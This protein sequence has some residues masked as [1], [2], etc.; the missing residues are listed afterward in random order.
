M[1]TKKI[2]IA[3][4]L[5]PVALDQLDAMAQERGRSRSDIIESLVSTESHGST[6]WDTTD[7]FDKAVAGPDVPNEW[8]QAAVAV[9]DTLRLARLACGSVF[10]LEARDDRKTAI[11]VCRMMLDT[12]ERMKADRSILVDGRDDVEVDD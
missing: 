9:C 6:T 4:R 3:A 2:Q 1:T 8:A 12:H 10:G 11:E 7:A 5:S